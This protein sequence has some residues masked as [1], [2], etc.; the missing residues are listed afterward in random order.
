MDNYLGYYK[1]TLLCSQCEDRWVF[2][3]FSYTDFGVNVPLEELLSIYPETADLVGGSR[4][5][6]RFDRILSCS[7]TR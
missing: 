1:V 3:S 7:L 2:D 6:T 4:V 5:L